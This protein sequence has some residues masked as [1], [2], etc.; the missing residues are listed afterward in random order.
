LGI[1]EQN[2]HVEIKIYP[3]PV[4]NKLNISINN[5]ELSEI[6]NIWYP[7]NNNYIKVIPKDIEPTPEMLLHM[8]LDDGCAYHRR[9]E[10]KIKQIKLTIS[11]QSF[12]RDDQEMFCEKVN[13]IFNLK[14]RTEATNSGTGYR[15]GLPQSKVN[16]FYNVIGPPPFE[17]LAY[18][19]K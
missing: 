15:I 3:N 16:D 7:K 11:S 19:W 14:M 10:S 6:Y 2:R 1:E 13:N 5:N 17:S 4:V 12:T 8:F 9:K 18:K